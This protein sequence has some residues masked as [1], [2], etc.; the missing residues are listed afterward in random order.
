MKQMPAAGSTTRSGRSRARSKPGTSVVLAV[1][2]GCVLTLGA[3]RRPWS[4]GSNPPP[5]SAHA[6]E[7]ASVDRAVSA[8]AP[9]VGLLVASVSPDGTC[10]PVHGLNSAAP[11]PT[12]S[13]FK[14]YVLGALADEI[15]AGRIS[16]EQPLTVEDA[17][18]SIGNGAGSLQLL[19][20]GSVVS[21]EE[22]ATKMISISDN[23]A[24]DMLIGLVGR[25]AVEAQ[26]G[27]WAGNTAANE[28]FLTTREMFLLHY[29]TGLADR[30]L[31]TPQGERD[32]FL[33]ASVD[34]LPLAAIASGL[35][36]DPRYIDQ[37]EW[38]ASPMQVCRAFAGLHALARQPALAPLST[39]LALVPGGNGPDASAWP[40]RWYKGGSE[41]GVLTLG[42]L[43]TNRHGRTF[44]VEAMLSN[45]DAVL[46][47][48]AIPDLVAVTNR[49]FDIVAEPG[50][51]RWR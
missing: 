15:A 25:D 36:A 43:A 16:W 21:V 26:V 30:Y 10:R 51:P 6:R 5:W 39:I 1:V 22:A 2:V 49:A 46:A 9:D 32:A 35:S 37:I 7:W 20:A 12:A 47:P 50:P 45:P 27:R 13:Q 33:A 14:L 42:W 29:V 44:V 38:F 31:A 40:T 41:P 3:C 23:T 34:P 11:R 17:V 28:P 19:P 48:T 18:R 8:M 24:A 4:S